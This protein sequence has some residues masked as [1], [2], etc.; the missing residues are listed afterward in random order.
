[1]AYDLLT[2]KQVPINCS[3]DA[4]LGPMMNAPTAA[5]L[6]AGG[7]ALVRIVLSEVKKE[8]E[9]AHY[10]RAFRP[11]HRPTIEMPAMTMG[12]LVRYPSSRE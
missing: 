7:M 10:Q 12:E 4:S 5:L 3:R 1:M 2:K 11:G 9:K 6:V 8:G